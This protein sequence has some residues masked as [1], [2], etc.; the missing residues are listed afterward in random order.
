MNGNLVDPT[1][2]MTGWITNVDYGRLVGFTTAPET[3]YTYPKS[4][5]LSITDN[6]SY[7]N[8][9]FS[10]TPTHL[11]SA[12]PGLITTPFNISDG[13]NDI[14]I[15]E[16]VILCLPGNITIFMPNEVQSGLRDSDGNLLNEDSVTNVTVIA[17]D[18]TSGLPTSVPHSEIVINGVR[19]SESG[20]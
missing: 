2:S 17:A 4:M 12:N 15:S 18:D 16:R 5:T 1:S 14:T 19:V 10:A 11:S 20:F 8:I 6:A 9:A 3:T 7:Q 13:T